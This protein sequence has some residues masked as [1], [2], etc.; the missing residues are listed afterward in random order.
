MIFSAMESAMTKIKFHLAEQPRS[1]LHWSDVKHEI[2]GW[3]HRDRSINELQTL[4]DRCLQDIGMSR[5]SADFE[6][7]K[8]FWMA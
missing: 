6:N 5:W 1:G 8:P 3:W 7:A 4:D 2:T